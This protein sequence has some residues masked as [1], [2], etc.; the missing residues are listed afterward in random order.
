MLPVGTKLG[1]LRLREVFVDYDGPQLFSCSDQAGRHLIAVHAPATS[2]GDNWL[3][4]YISRHRLQSVRAGLTSLRQAFAQPED[5]RIQIV[6]FD[7]EGMARVKTVIPGELSDNWYPHDSERLGDLDEDQL[8]EGELLPYANAWNGDISPDIPDF[9]RNPAP[10]WEV[11]PELLNFLRTRRT[12]VSEVARR[13]GRSVVDLVFKPPF[14]R[15]EM[16]ASVLGNL[17]LAAQGAVEAFAP[18]LA[19]GS[20]G[21]GARELSRLDA[22]PVFP[23]SFGLRLDAHEA[24]LVPNPRLVEAL[25]RLVSLLAA[26]G[27]PAKV[28]VLLRECGPG[29][30]MKFRSFA[31]AIEKSDADLSVEVGIPFT[32]ETSSAQVS[33]RDVAQLVELLNSEAALSQETFVFRGQLVGVT[34]GTKFFALEDDERIVSGRI[35]EAALASMFGKTIG[36]HYDA[37]ITAITDISEVTGRE[38]TRNIL[39]GLEPIG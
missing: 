26:A 19:P 7:F 2:E 11:S 25:Q 5:G 33:R 13:T 8:V 32:E 1:V 9:L 39:N 6:V 4:A 3:Y 34:L 10:M 35:A 24:N 22:L 30:A 23:G 37:N 28:R 14:D 18:P 31:Q 12:P 38:R 20:K 15:S 16:P 27:D 21:M 29:A 17:L 36:D